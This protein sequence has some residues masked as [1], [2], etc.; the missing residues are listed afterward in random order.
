MF[1]LRNRFPRSIAEPMALLDRAPATDPTD[2]AAL[3][4]KL[5]LQVGRD[6]DSEKDASSPDVMATA[7][8]LAEVAPADPLPAQVMFAERRRAVMDRDGLVPPDFVDLTRPGSATV[9]GLKPDDVA[10][11][12]READLSEADRT[13]VNE[14]GRRYR[15]EPCGGDD[16]S[17]VNGLLAAERLD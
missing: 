6:Y 10:H 15:P 8:R 5:E 1:A 3:R 17:L 13:S 7:R 16:G 2:A 14:A 4:L 11:S 12:F 9:R